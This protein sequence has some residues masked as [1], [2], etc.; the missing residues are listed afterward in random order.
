MVGVELDTVNDAT[1]GEPNDRPVV[2][3]TAASLRLP[4]ITHVSRRTRQDEILPV[5]I[6]HVAAGQDE[7]S[8]PE[9]GK[10]HFATRCERAFGR[11]HL[12]MHTRP[13]DASIRKNVETNVRYAPAARVDRK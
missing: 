12:S 4:A 8:I 2:A 3:R 6:V 9:R 11:H 5:P 13:R 1:P 7:A 10:I